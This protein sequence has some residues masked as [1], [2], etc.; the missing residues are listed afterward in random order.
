M[1]LRTARLRQLSLRRLALGTSLALAW[2]CTPAA[3]REEP[4]K[5]IDS[6]SSFAVLRQP[7]DGAVLIR[8]GV[9]ALGSDVGEV[10]QAQLMCRN[11]LGRDA[12]ETSLFADEMLLHEVVLSDFWIDRTEVTN[13]AYR[14]CV[15]V[16]SCRWAS[17]P[18]SQ[19]WTANATEPATLVTWFDANRY[20]RWRGARLP[21]EAEW[22]RAARG[23]RHR[24]YPWGNVYG[25]LLSNHGRAAA[26]ELDRFDESDGY[27]E[28]APVASFSA[29][30]T[31][32][33]VYDLAGNVEEWVADWYAEGYAEPEMHD[34]KGPLNGDF[35]VLR[36][37]SFRDGRAW[38]R[39]SRRHKELPSLTH[40]W[41]GFR[42]AENPL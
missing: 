26:Y 38:L 6:R 3:A 27:A 18:G 36:G 31:T 37:G 39:G 17:D 13:E 2:V 28:L 1:N 25:P 24:L 29:G 33:G 15:E 34:P 19:R 10:T 21:T 12:C 11:E 22:E 35:R 42:C 9:V 16:G 30:R 5:G 23:L 4:R 41:V 20:C 14:R 8:G 32:E 7:L 40:P